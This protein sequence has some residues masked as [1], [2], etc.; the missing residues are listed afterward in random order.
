MYNIEIMYFLKTELTVVLALML[1]S[2]LS[3]VAQNSGPTDSLAV[4]LEEINISSVRVAVDEPVTATTVTKQEI[5]ENFE[6]QDGAFLL[7]R[8]APSIVTYSESGTSFSNY[9]QMRLRGIDQTRINITLNG[10]PLN[11]MIDQGVFFSNMIDFG[12][13]LESVQIQRGVGTSTNG[14]ASYAGSVNFESPALTGSNSYSNI[15]LTGGSF[16]TFRAS[17]EV[18]TGLQENG[19]SFYARVSHIQSDGYRHNTSTNA[20]SF[21]FSGGYFGRKHSLK[22]TGLAGRS[23]NG[24]G[25]LPVD[26][27]DINIDPRTNYVSENDIDDFGQWLAQLQ[28]TWRFTDRQFLSSTLYYGGAGGDFPAGFTD[29]TGFVQINYPLYNHH[30]GL[31]SNY[32][33]RSKNNQSKF[34][35]GLHAY[36]FRRQ[37]LEYVIPNRANPYYDDRSQ[38]D[39][40]SVFGKWNHK[41]GAWQ[42]LADLQ[43]RTVVL[44]LTPDNVYLNSDASIPDRDYVF[45]NP[46]LGVSYDLSEK[47]QAYTSFGRSGREPTRFDILGS[48]QI[49]SGNLDNAINVNSIDPEYVNDLELGLRHAGNVVRVQANLFYMIFENEIAPIGEFIPEAFVQ[50]YQNQESS[51]RAGGELEVSWQPIKRLDVDVQAAY[52]RARISKYQPVGSTEV[53]NDVTPILSPELNGRI[54]LG[55]ELITKLK[56]SGEYRYLSSSF[57]ELTNQPSLTVPSSSVFNMALSWQFWKEH[58]FRIQVN[59]LTNVLYYTYGAPGSNGTDPAYFVQAPRNVYASLNLRF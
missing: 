18:S 25:Y 16:N 1:I 22:F 28:H 14:V 46:K 33:I 5:Q 6:G 15:E 44:S 19:T 30:I 27:A 24:L 55:Y 10:V 40:V 45:V 17:A 52:L 42:F 50:I 29:S 43:I 11:D 31:L 39:E 49:N 38:K 56:I 2:G 7:E 36:T 58:E 32:S 13:S 26:L 35:I 4:Q 21:F 34:N 54:R 8:L 9:G 53:F 59:N 51:Y 47:W 57:V 23:Q 41:A 48:T 12:N 20:N 37:N 3:L